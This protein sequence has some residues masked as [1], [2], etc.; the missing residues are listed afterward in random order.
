VIFPALFAREALPLSDAD[1]AFLYPGSHHRLGQGEVPRA[2]AGRAGAVLARLEGLGLE[3]R[4]ERPADTGVLFSAVFTLDTAS[5]ALAPT[6]RIR[7][8]EKSPK[9]Y[10]ARVGSCDRTE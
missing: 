1:P 9:V 2:L 6:V 3:L 5:G 7:Q 10:C 4:G 8:N